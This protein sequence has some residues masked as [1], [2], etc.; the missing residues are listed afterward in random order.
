MRNY[1]FLD[2][3]TVDEENILYITTSEEYREKPS[4]TWGREGAYI[5]LSSSFGPLEVALRL[6][7][8]DL[9]RRLNNLHPVP[10]LATTRQVTGGANS[11]LAL[12]ITQDERLVLRPTIVAD[13]SGHVIFNLVCTSEVRQTLLSWLEVEA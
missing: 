1:Q 2:V 4:L 8:D 13:A 5:T 10:G 11:F 12:G 7:R 3:A 9:M 6:R